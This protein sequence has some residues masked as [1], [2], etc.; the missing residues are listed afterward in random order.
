MRYFWHALI[1]IGFLA[2]IVFIFFIFSLNRENRI[3]FTDDLPE[4]TEPTVTIADP[5]LG[6]EDATVTIVNFG[7]YQCQACGEIEETL[8]EVLQEY[9]DDVRVVWKDMPNSTSHAQAINA[10]VAARCAAKQDAFDAYHAYLFANQNQLDDEIYTEI[11]RTLNLKER[12]FQN[13]FENQDTLPLVQ[14]SYEE[15]LA[16]DVTATPT[17]FI[18]GERFTGTLSKNQL[19]GAIEAALHAL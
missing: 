15:G 5:V 1:A 16:L 2:L 3:T 13:C 9:P 6:A 8:A 19:I 12:A 11:A 14:R 7:D 10:A 17:V 18:N 4:L